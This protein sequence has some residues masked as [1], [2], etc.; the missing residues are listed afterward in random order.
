MRRNCFFP[1]NLVMTCMQ[2]V[3]PAGAQQRRRRKLKR[4]VYQSQG[5]NYCW[6]IDGYDKL[7]PFGF[8]IHGCID[9]LINL[10]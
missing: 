8:A 5:P 9:G 1:R 6:H 3:D 10:F 7:K 2:E 4:R